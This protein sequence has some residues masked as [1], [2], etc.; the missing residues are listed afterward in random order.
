MIIIIII[1]IIIFKTAGVGVLKPNTVVFGF[2][3][4][5]QDSSERDVAIKPESHV[6]DFNVEREDNDLSNEEYL[7]CVKRALLFEKH[8]MI[9]RKF[10][11]FF[12]C[13]C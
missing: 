9:A 5:L 12:F 3:G 4:H 2:P 6:P 8:V 11:L 13:F 10:V 7:E 1:I